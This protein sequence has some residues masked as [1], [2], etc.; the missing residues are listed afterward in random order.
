MTLADPA[1]WSAVE[2]SLRVASTAVVVMLVPG[3]LA[4]WWLARTRSRWSGLVEA[5]VNLPLVLPPV[6]VGYLLLRLLGRRG[7]LG[8][9]L[10]DHLGLEI[11]FTWWAAAIA[12]AVMGFPLLVRSTRLAIELVERDLERAASGLG[13]GPLR[14]FV[15]VTLPLALP[16]VLAGAVLAFARSLGEFGATIL[17]AGNQPGATRT[18]ALS[19]WTETQSP[20]GE[21]RLLALVLV[22]IA[23][24]I[25]AMVV[26]EWLSRRLE[27]RLGRRR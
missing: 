10:H 4:A 11:A 18:L 16:G 27:R 6:V 22:A 9:S 24:S 13:A 25:A 8:A 14:T 23:I 26:A 20:D 3:V 2:I 21:D 15:R 19:I 1:V 17:V 7:W 5:I 12:S